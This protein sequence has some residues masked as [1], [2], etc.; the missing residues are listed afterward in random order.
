MKTSSDYSPIEKSRNF[1][2]TSIYGVCAYLGRKLDIP[3]KRVRLFF[4]YASFLALGSPVIVYLTLAFVL[5]L[6]Y[7]V[8][9]Q[10]NPVWDI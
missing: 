2:E 3:S 4:V 10:R 9:T 5:N 7:M 6:R 1:I 8:K